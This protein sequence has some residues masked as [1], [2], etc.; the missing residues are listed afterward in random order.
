MREC[1][2]LHRSRHVVRLVLASAVALA[3]VAV[4]P[5]PPSTAGASTVV[6]PPA[7]PAPPIAV[8]A[9]TGALLS[10]D[11][12]VASQRPRVT[13]IQVQERRLPRLLPVT[14]TL[15]PVPDGS[16]RLRPRI[17]GG[18]EIDISQAPWQVRVGY[19][20]G[21]TLVHRRWVMTAAH[22]VDGERAED[23]RV[24]SGLGDTALMTD[25]NALRVTRMKVHPRWDPETFAYDI[26]LLRLGAPAAG[27]P[28]RPY[29]ESAGPRAGTSGFI[30][31]W[32][33]QS[34][35]GVL[36]QQLNGAELSVLTGRSGTCG[37]YG[38][39]YVAEIMLCAGN[40][41]DTIDA[42]QGDS[43]GPLAVQVGGNWYVAGI[44]SF[45]VGCATPGYPGV[46]TRVSRLVPWIARTMGWSEP[47]VV[48]CRVDSCTTVT[49][50]GL[51]TGTGYLYRMRA[52]NT[53]G[54]SRWSKP[55]LAAE[56]MR[57]D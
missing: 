21:G 15:P 34:S 35:G 10:I 40:E 8:S 42:C 38:A 41:G 5:G 27:R 19:G 24:W 20:C 37:E 25:A 44:T 57:P 3:A 56:S 55:S 39:D 18:T 16:E 47:T 23:L 28:V 11:D 36:Q 9:P 7:R 29:H 51:D 32:G 49:I 17:V 26:A 46:Y 31:G 50:S 14:A 33:F 45:G 6:D 30:S 54:W 52:R 53:A 22:C 12:M 48:D 13:R 43:G 1:S 4:L 2:V